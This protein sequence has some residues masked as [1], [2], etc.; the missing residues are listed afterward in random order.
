MAG[1][2]CGAALSTGCSAPDAEV[3]EY[4]TAVL[5]QSGDRTVS[6]QEVVNQYAV[7]ATDAV[8]G[9]RSIT[10]QDL[11]V[12]PGLKAGDVLFIIQM[13]GAA[14]DLLSDAVRNG[15]VLDIR[16]A[17]HYELVTV[18]GV[19]ATAGSVQVRSHGTSGLQYDYT[20]AG[21]TQVILVPQY[22]NLT[23]PAGATLTASPWNGQTGGVVVVTA[24]STKWGVVGLSTMA[25]L[26][27]VDVLVTDDQL[28]EEAGRILAGK[29]GRLILAPTGS[30]LHQEAR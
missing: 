19:D 13:Q 25:R 15:E 5:G 21:H 24:D 3:A 9:S 14:I 4:R 22:Q 20:A 7:L 30:T 1:W 26:T 8:A 18:T 10:L 29:V 12:L 23:V 27:E 11:A 17:G 28:D 2:L 16:N 6:G